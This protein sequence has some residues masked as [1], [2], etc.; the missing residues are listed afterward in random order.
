MKITVHEF[1]VNKPTSCY[2]ILHFSKHSINFMN[3]LNIK[4]HEHW[5]LT[6]I[7]ET[8][9]YDFF[10]VCFNHAEKQKVNDTFCVFI[11]NSNKC[12]DHKFIQ[13][14]L[15]SGHIILLLMTPSFVCSFIGCNNIR[16]GHIGMDA[17][18]NIVSAAEGLVVLW[19][20]KMFTCFLKKCHISQW[21][22]LISIVCN[23]YTYQYLQ[24]HMWMFYHRKIYI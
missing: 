1:V 5:Y 10:P 8:A 24:C 19:I 3:Q 20:M 15:L 6:N 17:V 9:E 14:L 12:I 23:K 11:N 7:Y 21:S 16:Y 4:I 2:K 13:R 18:I 22:R